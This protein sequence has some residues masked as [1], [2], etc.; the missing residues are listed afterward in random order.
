MACAHRNLEVRTAVPQV[1]AEVDKKEGEW[2]YSLWLPNPGGGEPWVAESG[3]PLGFAISPGK[4]ETLVR[5]RVPAGPY[6]DR[7]YLLTLR[8]G[9]QAYSLRVDAAQTAF[10]KPGKT[11]YFIGNLLSGRVIWPN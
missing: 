8:Q 5:W 10:W 9:A 2:V 6:R 3:E 1:R 4:P 7:P 11:I